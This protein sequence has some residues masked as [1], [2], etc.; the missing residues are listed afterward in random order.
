MET[1][2]TFLRGVNMTCH[3][4]IKMTDL[5]SLYKDLGFIDAITYIQSGNVIF[6]GFNDLAASEI[7]LMIEKAIF[8]RFNYIIPV[9][10]RTAGELQKWQPFYFMNK[11]LNNR[12]KKLK[13]LIIPLISLRFPARRYSFIARTDLAEPN[14]TPI[15]SK[16]KWE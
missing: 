13:I 1:F 15:S 3:N 7:A 11:Q 2:I 8:E 9:M 16:R 4:S 6:T 5:S 10:I 12:F 14:Y